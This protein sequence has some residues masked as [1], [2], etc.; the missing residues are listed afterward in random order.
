MFT[1][2]NRATTELKLLQHLGSLSSTNSFL[3]TV[4]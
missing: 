4:N 2:R 3:L 1:F